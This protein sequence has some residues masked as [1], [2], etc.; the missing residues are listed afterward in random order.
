MSG[1]VPAQPPWQT[2][3]KQNTHGQGARLW[4]V[5][6]PEWPVRD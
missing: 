3:I 2:L 4:P 6:E 5:Q 1:K